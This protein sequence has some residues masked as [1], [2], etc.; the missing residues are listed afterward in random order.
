M[1][2]NP[3][4]LSFLALTAVLTI[5]PAPR[6]RAD[7]ASEQLAAASALFDAKRFPEAA[8][9]LQAFITAYPKHAR[10][11][12]AALTLGHCYASMQQWPK[13]AAAYDKAATSGDTG[14]APEA[15]L[16]FGIA[17]INSG[18]FEKAL[19]ALQRAVT[20]D[21]GRDHKAAAWFYIGQACFQTGKFPA[22]EEAYQK[23]VT[24]FSKVELVDSALL[25]SALSA[26]R[27]GNTDDARTRLRTLIQ[28]YPQS[29]E[30]PR[31]WLALAQIDSDAK[32]YAQAR[33]GFEAVLE[34]EAARKM[35]P[36]LQVP[37]EDGLIHVLLE[38]GDYPAA[39]SRLENSLKRLPAGDP[40]RYKAQLAL[41]HC[42]YRQKQYDPALS[43]YQDATKAADAAVAGEAIYWAGNV[44]LAQD[45]KVEAGNQLRELPAR[46][47][48]HPLA[49]KS[50]LKAGDAFASAGKTDLAGAAY[51]TVVDKYGKSDQADDARKALNGLADSITDPAQ[52]AIA[53]KSLPVEQ[54]PAS[55]LRLAR[56]Y[57]EAKKYAEMAAPLA[58]IQ[59][60]AAA[61]TVRAEARYLAGLAAEGKGSPPT[62]VA[63]A[64]TEAVTLNP[65]AEWA[66]HAQS[67]LA[68]LQL[69]L[70]QPA[71]AEA[72]ANSA[73]QLDCPADVKQEARLALVQAQLDQ[74][75]WDGA[76]E[77]SRALLE[78]NP[79]PETVA[80]VLYTQAWVS[81]QRGK[82]EE[83]LPN[84]ERLVKEF[85]KSPYAADA[86]L[87]VGDARMKAEKYDEAREQYEALV[88]SFPASPLKA[89]ARFKLGSA[90]FNLSKPAEA[91][92][93]FD[94]VAADKTAGDFQPEALYWA[95][96]A[97]EKEGKK[98]IAIQRLTRLV[99]DYPKHA[100]VEKARIHLA[101]LKATGT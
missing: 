80:T 17:S 40:Q 86:M 73:L 34:N 56:L 51:R 52:L 15:R 9:K 1:P 30:R 18:Q 31:A 54:R 53:I 27:Q 97:H 37:A 33:Q 39:S 10:V 16:R 32:R 50:A 94:A 81:E 19:P 96:V 4:A 6:A 65:K 92:V 41:G 23:V 88:K 44:L 55:D 98:D 71:K 48:T 84:W 3:K 2:S 46:F 29:E 5:L 13:A 76:L 25:G 22:A 79:P 61:T 74:K 8:Q 42:R 85:A 100:R 57:L 21:L 75:K 83:A 49:A 99:T 26:L 70:K 60:S 43:A 24:D 95:G 20:E 63:S 68:W 101:A 62:A 45:K 11:G 66:A 7:D 47:P 82:S 91:A 78:G 90:L 72:A 64:F 38:S 87:H 58:E 36:E 28:R 14:L 77:T 93:E 35:G 59:Q 67:R 12:A 69:E 89:E